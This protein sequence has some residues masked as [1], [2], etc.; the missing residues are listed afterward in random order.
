MYSYYNKLII[1]LFLILLSYINMPTFAANANDYDNMIWNIEHNTFLK[2]LEKNEKLFTKDKQKVID[3]SIALSF[4]YELVYTNLQDCIIAALDNNYDIKIQA[5][6]KQTAYH[7]Y[8]AKLAE[9]LPNLYYNFMIANIKGTYLVGEILP[10]K[11]NEI[12]I[13]SHYG[14][15]WSTYNQ[16]KVI[17][18]SRALKNNLKAQYNKLNFTKDEIILNTALAYYDLLGNKLQIEVLKINLVER[19]EQLRYTKTLYDIGDGTRF[20]VLRAEVEV[21]LAQKELNDSLKNL[22]LKQAKLAN[23]MGIDVT[24]SIYPSE[25]FIDT[26]KVVNSQCEIE[27]LYTNAMVNR[28]DIAEK[29]ALI[30]AL[31][32]EK[33]VVYSEFLPNFT[34]QYERANVGTAR[35]GLRQNDTLYFNIEIPIGQNLG[36]GTYQHL[37]SYEAKIRQAKFELTNLKRNIKENII[38]S[39]YESE[40]NL[41]NIEV[42][43][44]EIEAADE[45]LRNAMARMMIGE[46]TFLDVLNAQKDKTQ[47][48]ITF[49]SNIIDYNKSQVQLLFDAGAISTNAVLANYIVPPTP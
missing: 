30:K 4:D 11:L 35:L 17:F 34:L 3:G 31:E 1:S 8:K 21:A 38:N 44:K 22:R 13:E 27:E 36:I 46:A 24:A 40:T 19:E 43:K 16:G 23:I 7:E 26:V 9:F 41:K 32:E 2:R 48:R 6:K 18:E 39:Y 10:V 37:K 49:I 20:D 29:K 14:V 28:K 33:K 25:L 47:A 15:K 12:P 5:M 42:N 45:S